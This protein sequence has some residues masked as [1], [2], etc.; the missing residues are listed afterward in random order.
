MAIGQGGGAGGSGALQSRVS[1]SQK[2]DWESKSCEFSETQAKQR[3]DGMKEVDWDL[4]RL[5]K[6]ESTYRGQGRPL[7]FNKRQRPAFKG[8]H[9]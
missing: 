5:K 6:M 2:G 8:R 4:G 7:N 9:K 1:E 3:E